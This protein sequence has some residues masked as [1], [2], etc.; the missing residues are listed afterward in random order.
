MAPSSPSLPSHRVC[1]VQFR[2]QLTRASARSDGRVEPLVSGQA[3][4]FHSLEALLAFMIQV[5]ADVQTPPD[6]TAS[7]HTPSALEG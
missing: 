2:L 7:G 5:L 4:R 1:V 3:V 6:A